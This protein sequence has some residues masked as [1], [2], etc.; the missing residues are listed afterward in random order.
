ML[1][2]AHWTVGVCVCPA[3]LALISLTEATVQLIQHVEA[4]LEAVGERWPV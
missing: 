3:S 2:H 4:V 1:Q